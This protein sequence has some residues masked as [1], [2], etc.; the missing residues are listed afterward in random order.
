MRSPSWT[1]Y[2]M[3]GAVQIRAIVDFSSIVRVKGPRRSRGP[4]G[5]RGRCGAEA[6]RPARQAL[7]ARA[8]VGTR[9]GVCERVTLR[10]WRQAWM[11]YPEA[12][13]VAL[14]G[15]WALSRR[16]LTR[17]VSVIGPASR[18]AAGSWD[19]R[20][21]GGRCW[22]PQRRRYP[23]RRLRRCWYCGQSGK[24]AL[25]IS[26]RIRCPARKTLAVPARSISRRAGTPGSRKDSPSYPSR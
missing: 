12:T 21:R 26:N 11:S 3:P 13:V 20:H 15:S 7:R 24:L 19:E 25:L 5:G 10:P 14:R 22:L 16:S 17:I 1:V 4:R 6:G 8:P 9:V 18:G 23:W 2:S